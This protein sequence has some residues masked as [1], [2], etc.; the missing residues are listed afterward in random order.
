MV[1]KY[2]KLNQGRHFF[3]RLLVEPW[4]VANVPIS[5]AGSRRAV[6]AV[7][8]N[9]TSPWMKE[10]T[11]GCSRCVNIGKGDFSSKLQCYEYFLQRV[12]VESAR[13]GVIPL[14]PSVTLKPDL[15]C[16]GRAPRSCD[17]TGRHEEYFHHLGSIRC[18]SK[19][20]C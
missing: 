20:V 10:W 6:N 19:W 5:N 3:I 14:P 7:A 13:T 15:R 2:V 8:D 17:A 1:V 11:G 9:T 18:H 4:V 12:I 16:Y